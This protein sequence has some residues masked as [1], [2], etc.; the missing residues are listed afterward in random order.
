MNK[1]GR[2]AIKKFSVILFYT[3]KFLRNIYSKFLTRRAEFLN[4]QYKL[5]LTCRKLVAKGLGEASQA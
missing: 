2:T 3:E 5:K 1:K 4:I